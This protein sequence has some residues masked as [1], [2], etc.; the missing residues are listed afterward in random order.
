MK[1]S[2]K[3]EKNYFAGLLAGIIA[4]TAGIALPG[5]AAP[6][7]AAPSIQEF[8]VPPTLHRLEATVAHTQAN[9]DILTKIGPGYAQG[10]KVSDARYVFTA[11]DRVEVH[12]RYGII[13]ATV[14]YTNTT[15]RVNF[16]FIHTTKNISKDLTKRQTIFS[17]GLLPQNYLETVRAQYLGSEVAAGVPCAVFMLQ[18]VGDLPTDKRRFQIWVSKDKHYVVKKRVWDG[19]NTEHETIIYSN[20]VQAAPGI[21]VPTQV[22]AFD[23]QGELGGT[24]VQKNISAN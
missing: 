1:I 7:A 3:L 22:Q 5:Y 13:S 16:G 23:P 19:S 18:Y 11:P 2:R 15:M 17:L 21:W 14:V 10:Y 4:L 9:K 24:A 8:A 6:A 12:G 20:P